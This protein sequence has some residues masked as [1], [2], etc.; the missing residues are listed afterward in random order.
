MRESLIFYQSFARA[1]KKLPESEQLKAL[2]S[3]I[4]Y[5]LED[6]EPDGD[7][8]YMVVY[9]MA[10]PQIDANVERKRNGSR[11]GRPQKPQE[12]PKEQKKTVEPVKKKEPPPYQ[13]IIDYLNEKAG[14]RFKVNDKTKAHIN[15]RVNDGYT[16]ADFR[17]VIEKKVAEWR[18]TEMDKFL[19]PETLFGTKF[20]GY[21]NQN[22]TVRKKAKSTGFS[23]FEER[24]YDFD[25]LERE[26]LGAQE[27]GT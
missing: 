9:E 12:K 18:G 3:I 19:R 14:K 24:N 16:L 27:G 23:N 22:E 10:K 2:W 15:A 13:E 1:I 21:L 25:A 4:D 17:A 5:A 7:G 26:L 20:E 11:G 6:K 8:M